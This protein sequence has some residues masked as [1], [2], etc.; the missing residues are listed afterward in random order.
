[1]CQSRTAVIATLLPASVAVSEQFGAFSGTL[2]KDEQQ[3][4][5]WA[6][7]I[8]QMEFAAGRSCAREALKTLGFS[9]YPVLR[10]AERQPLW[11]DGIVGS[12]TH[13]KGYCAAAV[14]YA[15]QIPTL[16]ID[17][18]PDEPLPDGVLS[19]IAR[20][21]E[22]EGLL[23]CRSAC[24]RNWDRLLFSAKE[25]TYKAWHPITRQWL[26]FDEVR[27]DIISEE[28]SFNVTFIGRSDSK[29]SSLG[30]V[31]KYRIQRGLVLTSVVAQLD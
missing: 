18:E 25:S 4:L 9:D 24:P 12:I 8:R 2:S 31:G 5:G 21:E 3:A 11:P 17:A 26:D 1:M 30:L 15:D 23:K 6:V 7:P 13:C 22:I 27:I 20:K 16:G 14:A 28:N 19:Q 10:G 29:I